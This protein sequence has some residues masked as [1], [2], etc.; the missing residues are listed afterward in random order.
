MKFNSELP[1][2]KHN[3]KEEALLTSKLKFNIRKKLVKRY[4]WNKTLY[5]AETW[6]LLQVNQNYHLS[7]EMLL[8]DGKKLNPK[9]GVAKSNL[10]PQGYTH[11]L[12][13]IPIIQQNATSK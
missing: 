5:R 13:I 6:T 1:W 9:P 8:E 4:V 3:L 2:H 12:E 7:F 10:Y 11:H